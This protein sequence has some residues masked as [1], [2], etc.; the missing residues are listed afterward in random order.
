MH[1][2]EPTC[3]Q[4]LAAS[5]EVP[6]VLARLMQHV[7]VNLR[8][9]A[10]WVG[11]ETAVARAEHDAMLRVAEACE[12]IAR[13]AEHTARLMQSMIGLPPAPHD[14]ARRDRAEF[15]TWMRTKIGLQRELANMLTAH[16]LESE[17][18]L[19]ALAGL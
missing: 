8:A 3:G 5:A 10:R 4:E 16:A 9:H 2:D 19:E 17:R 6:S 1:E 18:A 7:A 11:A 15:A 13:S 14:P 12:S